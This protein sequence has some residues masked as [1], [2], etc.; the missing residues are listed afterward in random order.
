MKIYCR[1]E[2]QEIKEIAIG[3]NIPPFDGIIVEAPPKVLRNPEAWRYVDGEF[4]LYD[5]PITPET[6]TEPTI[7]EILL[8]ALLE[9]QT[10]KQRV[11]ELE[12][13]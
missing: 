3:Y 13:I 5:A 11:D 7:E 6:T 1:I 8:T 12:G 4:V 2:N 10:L 9:I